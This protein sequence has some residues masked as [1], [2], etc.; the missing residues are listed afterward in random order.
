[1]ANNTPKAK[2]YKLKPT[3]DVMTRDDVAMWEYTLLAACRQVANWRQF[4]PGQNNDT[5][6]A[7]DDD[8]NNGN[9]LL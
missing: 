6:T 3:N 1:M 2:P 7:T 4:L 9:F 5:W 8:V